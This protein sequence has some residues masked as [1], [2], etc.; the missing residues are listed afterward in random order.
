MKLN[1]LFNP[2]AL[3]ELRQ[4]VR[5][6]IITVG[7]LLYPIALTI[8]TA[9]C[10][11]NQM[12]GRS[13]EDIMLG[14][15]LGDI[16]FAATAIIAGLVVCAGLPIFAALKTTLEAQKDRMG[17]EFITTLT[18]AD[19]VSG[20]LQAT[21]L[22]MLGALG[23]SMPF[24]TLAYL[25]RGITLLQT[26][27]MPLSLFIGG[28][29]ALSLLMIIACNKTW[30]PALR[31]IL[32]LS[33][34]GLMMT[35]LIA[36]INFIAYISHRSGSSGSSSA[37][38]IPLV[39]IGA[40]AL[41]LI[42]RATCATL[43]S[44]PHHDAMR[45]LRRTEFFLYLISP[46]VWLNGSDAFDA[47][48]IVSAI[49]A[50]IVCLRS[51]F[52]PYPIPRVA[53]LSA[54]RSFLG[55]FFSFA[56]TTGSVPGLVFGLRI[57]F[58]AI[59]CTFFSNEIDDASSRSRFFTCFIEPISIAIIVGTTLRTCRAS[60]RGYRIAATVCIVLFLFVNSAFIL[61]E[62]DVCSAEAFDRLPCCIHGMVESYSSRHFLMYYHLALALILFL[63][64]EGCLITSYVRAFRA[65]K[66]PQ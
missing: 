4:L 36:I 44:A 17:L 56:F 38:N 8:I 7:L 63:I 43:L 42:S 53:N 59:V 5:S 37:F 39:I 33:C 26:F 22:L 21:A 30:A 28:L 46:L 31:I 14:N 19:I 54:P 1:F 13:P 58:V 65:Y 23:L 15:G 16:P 41:V 64:A 18:P 60:L 6:R 10:V 51:A 3:R 55:R 57:L 24:F 49:F 27:M 11:S 52:Y 62:F 50:T 12:E 9:L 40:I 45:P 25:M 47:W 2:V 32:G 20:K 48:I 35:M 29:V 34:Y 66:R 61:H